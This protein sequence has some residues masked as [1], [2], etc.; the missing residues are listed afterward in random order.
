MIEKS[1][2][3][4]NQPHPTKFKT[5]PRCREQS[6]ERKRDLTKRRLENH[7][8]ANCGDHE[9]SGRYYCDKCYARFPNASNK[10]RFAATRYV[11]MQTCET[12]D[13]GKPAV[14]RYKKKYICYD[15]LN[16]PLKVIDRDQ[17]IAN[18]SR[19]TGGIAL[20]ETW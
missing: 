14:D 12:K 19:T 15:C 3:R 16:E 1:C 6:K 2:N 20:F 17:Y 5:C 7:C 9:P 11:K 4:C 8:C 18:N 13:C 10:N